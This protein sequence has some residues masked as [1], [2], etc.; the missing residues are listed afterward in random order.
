[1]P[2]EERFRHTPFGARFKRR[3]LI[4]ISTFLSGQQPKLREME[5]VFFYIILTGVDVVSQQTRPCK[6]KFKQ[7]EAVLTV[8]GS[9]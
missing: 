2:G 5:L 6:A 9:G 1:M 7:D 3:P 8:A 4:E